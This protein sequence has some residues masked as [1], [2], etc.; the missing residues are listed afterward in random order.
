VTVTNSSPSAAA[1]ARTVYTVGFTTSPPN[2]GLSSANCQLTITLPSG[3][4]TSTLANGV[5]NDTTGAHRRLQRNFA[6]ASK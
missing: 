6:K 4:D 3:I 2:G 5:V 1:G